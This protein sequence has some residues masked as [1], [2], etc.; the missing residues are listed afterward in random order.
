MIGLVMP[1][2]GIV[3]F[4]FSIP[5]AEQTRFRIKVEFLH[6]N[7]GSVG[8]VDQVLEI[9]V[10][11]ILARTGVLCQARLDQIVDDVLVQTAIERDI[12]AT[13]DGA[14]DVRL[15]RGTGITG[16]DNNPLGA[17]VVGLMQPLGANGMV[18][19]R[20]GSDVHDDIGVLH[21]APMSGH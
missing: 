9:V 10:V 8:V 16:V 5:T 17:L 20:I 2:F 15:L 13:A 18:F 7:V 12:R 14:I 1:G 3:A 21:V 4:L 6:E 11:G 19:N